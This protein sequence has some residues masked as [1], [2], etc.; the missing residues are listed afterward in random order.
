MLLAASGE[1]QEAKANETLAAIEK[2]IEPLL[3][4]AGPF[5]GGR[6]KMTLAEAIVA[7]FLLRFY[8]LSAA[9]LLPKSL[10]EGIQK[11]PNTGKWAEH[12]LKQESVLYIWNEEAVV[13]RTGKRIAKM[14]EQK[15]K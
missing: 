13:E 5:F 1:E 15:G 12:V 6:E 9:G 8:A 2:E 7:P 14:K 10:K 11:L 4:D 3:K